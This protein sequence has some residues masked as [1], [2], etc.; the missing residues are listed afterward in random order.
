MVRLCDH[1]HQ[2]RI[3]RHQGACCLPQHV[4][5]KICILWQNNRTDHQSVENG[6]GL[7]TWQ[8]YPP[9][10]TSPR[11]SI[12]SAASSI[13]QTPIRS[14]DNWSRRPLVVHLTVVEHIYAQDHGCRSEENGISIRLCGEVR[15]HRCTSIGEA[16]S[17]ILND[18]NRFMV[19]DFFKCDDIS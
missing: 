16:A 13:D 18:P 1:E 2:T 10:Q 14:I 4:A 7:G 17:M 3:S 5:R 11:L 9:R 19:T 6:R 15:F 8:H 12:Q